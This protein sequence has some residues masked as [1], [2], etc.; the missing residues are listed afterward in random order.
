MKHAMNDAVLSVWNLPARI[1]TAAHVS[2]VYL[3]V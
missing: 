1:A 3:A 2:D